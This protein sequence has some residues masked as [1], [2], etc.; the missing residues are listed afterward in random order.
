M[1]WGWG[2]FCKGCEI[3]WTGLLGFS[4][5]SRGLFLA[6]QRVLGSLRIVD[7]VFITGVF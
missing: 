1:A 2:A 4:W 7:L 6:K 3:I 5:E